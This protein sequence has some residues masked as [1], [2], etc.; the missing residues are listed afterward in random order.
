MAAGDLVQTFPEQRRAHP[1]RRAETAAFVGE[2]ARKVDDDSQQVAFLAEHHE[3]TAG[4]QILEAEPA[5]EF[6]AADQRA[7]RAADLHRLYILCAA[8]IQHL[9]D[10]DAER[11]FIDAWGRAVAADAQYLAARRFFRAGWT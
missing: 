1:A 7:G 3:R 10:A 5:M 8:V 4:G 11:V 6:R 9:L 2:E